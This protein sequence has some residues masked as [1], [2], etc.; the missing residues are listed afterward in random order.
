M[1]RQKRHRKIEQPPGFKGYMPYGNL[2]GKTDHIDL[3]YEEYE[4]IKL[5][6]YD[7]MNHLEA[8]KIMG[9]SRPTFARIYEA[10]RRKIAK[11]LV[12]TRQI[13]SVCG[14]ASFEESWH[15]CDKCHA[16]FTLPDQVDTE[17]CPICKSTNIQSIIPQA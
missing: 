9:V 8:S 1:P 4:A 16:R 3:L 7:L 17:H 5:A 13:K 2:R 6:D 15:I 12:E 11:A 10:A 14:F